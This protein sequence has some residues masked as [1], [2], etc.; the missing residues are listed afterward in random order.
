MQSFN[1]SFENE[2]DQQLKRKEDWNSIH[3]K[4]VAL[5]DEL[6]CYDEDAFATGYA[7]A[8]DAVMKIAASYEQ[9]METRLSEFDDVNG[10]E[11]FEALYR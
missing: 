4:I 1:L 2:V 10:D 7:E 5:L 8:E 3:E 9:G 11:Q 6:E